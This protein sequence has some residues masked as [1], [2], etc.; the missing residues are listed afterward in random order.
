ME[1]RNVQCYDGFRTVGRAEMMTVEGGSLQRIIEVIRALA[2]IIS[3]VA[4]L[5]ECVDDFIEGYKEGLEEAR[6]N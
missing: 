2:N 6:G 4:E 1:T 3:T 5:T